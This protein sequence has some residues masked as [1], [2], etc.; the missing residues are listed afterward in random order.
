VDHSLADPL[1]LVDT[2]TTPRCDVTPLFADAVALRTVAA[3]LA[4]PFRGEVDAVA[5]ID[6]LGFVL[7]TA[8]A[9]ELGVGVVT[10]RKGGKLPVTAL[11]EEFVDYSGEAKA[12]ELRPGI[13]TQGQRVLIVD[14]WVET[15]T[16]VVAAAAL[17]ERAG[18]VVAGF[19]A[20][21]IDQNTRTDWLRSRYWCV[22]IAGG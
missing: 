13:L 18:S 15:G 5:A 12:L 11:R 3:R 7:G 21:N 10:V 19:A 8:V 1:A 2:S 16:Q 6:A 4:A 17:I 9:L 22:D 20:I 14:E